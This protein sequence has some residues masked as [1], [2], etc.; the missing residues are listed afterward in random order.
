M[1]LF[2]GFEAHRFFAFDA[3]PLLQSRQIKPALGR[4]SLGDAFC[5]IADQAVDHGPLCPTCFCLDEVRY[6]NVARHEDISLDARCS[7]ICG[8]RPSGLSVSW[9]RN[10]GNSQ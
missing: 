9:D 10:F 6:R 5:A 7:G 1:E 4:L 2:G 3:T 8:A